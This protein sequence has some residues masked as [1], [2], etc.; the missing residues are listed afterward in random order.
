[1]VAFELELTRADK[2]AKPEHQRSAHHR[3]D[4]GV[5]RIWR[6]T[7]A[8]RVAAMRAGEL[9]LRQ[10]AA[11]SAQRPDE[12]PKL[13]FLGGQEFEWIV[14]TTPEWIEASATQSPSNKQAGR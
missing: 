7:A 9:S 2:R 4:G 3:Y 6:M 1:M 13:P 8:E 5:E 12:V 10:L 14:V 11:W